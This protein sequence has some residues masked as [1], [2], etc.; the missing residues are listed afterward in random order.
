MSALV[1]SETYKNMNDEN[2]KDESKFVSYPVCVMIRTFDL[3]VRGHVD[4]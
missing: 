4:A 1:A 3:K 2:D